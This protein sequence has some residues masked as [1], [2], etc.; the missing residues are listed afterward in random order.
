MV[1][2]LLIQQ[3]HLPTIV[4]R[5]M[6]IRLL[7][8]SSINLFSSHFAENSFFLLLS[9]YSAQT[10]ISPLLVGVTYIPTVVGL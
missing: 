3:L 4:E 1:V 6:K 9:L 2:A 8:M 7:W 10:V 5:L